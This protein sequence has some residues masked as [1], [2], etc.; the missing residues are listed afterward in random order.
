LREARAAVARVMAALLVVRNAA[1]MIGLDDAR[2]SYSASTRESGSATGAAGGAE[3]ADIV[4]A[5]VGTAAGVAGTSPAARIAW[6]A[7]SC[8]AASVPAI[9]ETYARTFSGTAASS[10]EACRVST[11]ESDATRA[12]RSA[13]FGSTGAT[14]AAAAD[15][16]TTSAGASPT[17]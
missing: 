15:V 8:F 7:S 16:S 14:G 12:S 10:A 17:T 1:A 9:C 4:V 13:S 11:D 6:S 3:G 5:P 2:R